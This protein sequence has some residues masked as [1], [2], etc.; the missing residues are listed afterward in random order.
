MK[1]VSYIVIIVLALIYVQPASAGAC[2]PEPAW[3]SGTGSVELGQDFSVLYG[4]S[5][6]SLNFLVV[7][8]AYS[9]QIIEQDINGFTARLVPL[10]NSKASTG[11]YTYYAFGY[12]AVP[13]YYVNLPLVIH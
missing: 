9:Y 10:E 8:S 2:D 5:L 4:D 3:I 7:D 13:C 1:S 12:R 6:Q 11:S